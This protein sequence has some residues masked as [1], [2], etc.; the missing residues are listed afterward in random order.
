MEPT[1]LTVPAAGALGEDD[2]GSTLSRAR[3]ASAEVGTAA[4][5]APDRHDLDQAAADRRRS[6]PPP[7]Q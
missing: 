5:A 2:D 1:D 7:S 6:R 4:T 3:R